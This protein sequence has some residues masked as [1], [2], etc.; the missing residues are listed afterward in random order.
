ML[1]FFFRKII[2]ISVFNFDM[3]ILYVFFL[4]LLSSLN[5]FA[6]DVDEMEK[7]ANNGNLEAQKKLGIYY[8]ELKQ[9]N[10]K[11][12]IIWF[13]KA[14]AQGDMKS[15]SWLGY[16]YEFGKGVSK[17]YKKAVEYYQVAANKGYY[18]AQYRLGWCYFYGRGVKKSNEEAIKWFEKAAEKGEGEPVYFIGAIYYY[19]KNGVN[20]DYDKAVKW[21]RKGVAQG[22]PECQYGLGFCYWKGYGVNRDKAEAERLIKMS[23]RNGSCQA[24][25]FVRKHYKGNVD[26]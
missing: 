8:I 19:G 15:I 5:S 24:W 23:A 26:F 4:V 12:A 17:N 10:Y 14:A 1:T 21:W 3:K 6:F 7:Q 13:E 11:K 22:E 16:I 20:K 18:Y 25:R 9:P 2:T